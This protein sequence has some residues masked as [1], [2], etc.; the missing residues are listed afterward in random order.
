MPDHSTWPCWAASS[1]ETQNM[2]KTV[3]T[4]GPGGVYVGQTL[5]T[6]GDI[7]PLEP[8]VYLIPA[9]STEIAPP[10]A[11]PGSSAVWNGSGW[12][13]LPTPTDP[14]PEIEPFSR[15]GAAIQIDNAVAAIYGRFTRFALEYEQR[16]ASAQAFKDAGYTGTVPIRVSEFAEPAGLTATAAADLVLTQAFE[17]RAAQGVLSMLRMRKFEVLR[18]ASDSAA[19]SVAQ[20]ILAAIAVVGANIQ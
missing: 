20:E 11:P 14:A 1:F 15:P 19:E 18:A 6:E 9:R 13:T 12:L 8:G 10:D 16:E 7:S 2:T 4:F 17:L 5:L 3:Y